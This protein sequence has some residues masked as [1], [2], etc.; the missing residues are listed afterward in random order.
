SWHL[1]S[2]STAPGGAIPSQGSPPSVIMPSGAYAR[3]SPD[4]GPRPV[5]PSSP[6]GGTPP[7]AGGHP[8]R[9]GNFYG[10]QPMAR[11]S[12]VAV[13]YPV[14]DEFARI[15]TGVLGGS[16]R[17]VF[18]HGGPEDEFRETM[19]RA[20]VLIG[21]HLGQE[22]PAGTWQ[23]VPRLRFVQLLSAGADSV[24]FAAIPERLMLASNVGAYAKP[25]AEYVMAGTA[26]PP[27]RL[28]PAPAARPRG[29][30]HAWR[31]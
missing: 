20:D 24:D 29:A 22:V 27:P 8:G 10:R 15:N 19:R 28:P 13:S 23:D 16:A 4:G 18:L 11:E 2:R 7:V 14:D 25:M 12:L 6:P 31:T 30:L 1:P 3:A 26:A 21:W 5:R 9:D 17:V